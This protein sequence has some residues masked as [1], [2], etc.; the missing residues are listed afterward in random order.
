MRR[1]CQVALLLLAVWLGPTVRQAAAQTPLLPS[2]PRF[3]DIVRLAQN[4]YGDSA[5]T[6]IDGIVSHLAPDDP[7]YV[8]AIYTQG[9]VARTGPEMRKAFS[10]ILVDH[11]RSAWADRAALRLAE[12]DYGSNNMD[13]V[14]SRITQLLVDFP[15][16]PVIP[17]ATLWGARAAFDRGHPQQACDWLTRGLAA[18]GDDLE[19]RNQLQFAK[20]ACNLG[21]G[22]QYAPMNH[23]SLRAGPPP[24]DSATRPATRPSPV[25]PPPPAG[26]S[27]HPPAGSWRVQ[28]GALNAQATIDRVVKKI[29]AAGYKAYTIP[30]PN[31]FTRVQAGPFA[32]R[33][34][35]SAAIAK[36]KAAVGGTPFVTQ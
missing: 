32:T 27:A 11:A 25:A 2:T 17:T 30:G 36:L 12:L 16:S 4:G 9:V 35:A 8:E 15:K 29:E 5:R 34:A 3:Q 10:S 24:A 19:T 21:P 20:Q 23:D 22:V 7:G 1:L 33:A 26:A 28:V 14:I 18:V 31:G 6:L 13:L